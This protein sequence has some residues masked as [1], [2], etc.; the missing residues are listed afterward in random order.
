[1]AMHKS[2]VEQSVP[3]G[4]DNFEIDDKIGTTPKEFNVTHFPVCSSIL[5]WR[6]P[7]IVG[8]PEQW[9]KF[10]CPSRFRDQSKRASRGGEMC[11]R[12][13]TLVQG[14]GQIPISIAQ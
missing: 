11:N 5:K 4:I 10:F 2:E 13:A 7:F 6:E 9:S 12:A 8:L 14:S 1:M 3:L